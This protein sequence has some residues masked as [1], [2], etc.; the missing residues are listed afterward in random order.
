M[1]LGLA[2]YRWEDHGTVLEFSLNL[3]PRLQNGEN[4][5][6]CLIG[7]GE[8]VE[9][10]LKDDPLKEGHIG[11]KSKAEKLGLEIGT[12]FFGCREKEYRCV[13]KCRAVLFL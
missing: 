5:I 7:G 13:Q 3:F 9:R 12:L 8:L 6:T 10:K 4:N 1:I 2:T 11:D